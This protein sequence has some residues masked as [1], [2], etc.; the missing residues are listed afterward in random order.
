MIEMCDLRT[1]RLTE[2]GWDNVN[3]IHKILET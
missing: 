1:L 2:G 3:L